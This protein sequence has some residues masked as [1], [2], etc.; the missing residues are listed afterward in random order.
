M[1]PSVRVES[2]KVGGNI[3]TLTL[4][5]G[6]T[7]NNY[8]PI[9]KYTV[10]CSGDFTCPPDF[11]TSDITTRNYTIFNLIPMTTYTFSVVATNSF[12]DGEAGLLT[13]TIPPGNHAQ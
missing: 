2:I 1:V 5:W 3:A 10:S 11:S 13:Y 8:D 9:V 7:F 6:E 12:G 4:S